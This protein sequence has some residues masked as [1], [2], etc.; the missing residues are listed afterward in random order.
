M[1]MLRSVLL[2]LPVITEFTQFN[3]AIEKNMYS[4]NTDN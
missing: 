2:L 1:I 4:C 3:L